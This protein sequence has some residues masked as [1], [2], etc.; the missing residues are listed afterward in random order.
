MFINN[1]LAN[2]Y[3]YLDLPNDLYAIPF[4]SNLNENIKSKIEEIDNINK[5]KELSYPKN[6]QINNPLITTSKVNEEPYNR[7]VIVATNIAEASITINNLS[8]VIDDGQR[9]IL[10]YNEK[11]QNIS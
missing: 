9:M 6:I 2:I 4:F 3:E 8:F 5:R 11:V 10:Q 7:F 1:I